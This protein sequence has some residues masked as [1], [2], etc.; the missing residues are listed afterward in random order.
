MNSSL[1]LSGML[2]YNGLSINTATISLL[3][4]DVSI[5]EFLLALQPIVVFE[6]VP[7]V[8]NQYR[9]SVPCALLFN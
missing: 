6:V 3:I 1:F 9:L 4:L 8:A 7:T 5:R 2:K